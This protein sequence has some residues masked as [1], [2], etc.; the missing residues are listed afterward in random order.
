MT[1]YL[2]LLLSG[3]ALAGCASVPDVTYNYYL[4]K[5]NTVATVTQT[6]ACNSKNNAV[7]SYAAPVVVPAYAADYARGAI[8]ISLH[9]LNSQW[10]DNSFTMNLMPDG[11]L[12]GSSATWTG[13]GSTIL[14]SA[15]TAASTVMAF[16]GALPPGAVKATAGPSTCDI[17]AL[18][19]ADGKT[20]TFTYTTILQPIDLG[21]NLTTD[22]FTLKPM[23]GS[24]VT[25]V[26]QELIDSNLSLPKITLKIMQMEK[27]DAPLKINATAPA[28]PEYF[29]LQKLA[30]ASYQVRVGTGILSAGTVVVPRTDT[31]GTYQVPITGAVPFGT[32]SFAL[33]TQSDG[34]AG[35]ATSTYGDNAGTT[36]ANVINVVNSGLSAAK[37]Q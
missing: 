6:I 33:T 36:T 1:R 21:G 15:I 8:P 10:A 13:Q 32:Q 19:A 23:G 16:G 5:S 24:D 35:L 14:Q 29:T 17:V 30:R 11:R 34:S 18:K 9:N 37:P 4:T 2:A 7:V 31:D 22:E 28:F 3:A 20:L 25:D 26:R 12:T 27:P